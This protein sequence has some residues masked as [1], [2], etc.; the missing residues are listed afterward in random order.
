MFTS[1]NFSPRNVKYQMHNNNQCCLHV[2]FE[3]SCNSLLDGFSVGAG[4][5]P[6]CRA[7]AYSVFDF[8]R[9]GLRATGRRPIREPR[10]LRNSFD[11]R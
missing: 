9:P 1:I 3:L 4:N 8:W 11:L 2:V 10:P 7:R 5:S 6:V